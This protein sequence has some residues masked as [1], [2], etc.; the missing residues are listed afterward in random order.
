MQQPS[1]RLEPATSIVAR[2]GGKTAV[3]RA[4]GLSC[5][6]IWRWMQH[7]SRQGTGG[8]IPRVH[9]RALLV[10][11]QIHQIPLTQE[12]LSPPEPIGTSLDVDYAIQ[13][14]TQA[15]GLTAVTEALGVEV[16]QIVSFIATGDIP[17]PVTDDP[18]RL[19][20]H[21]VAARAIRSWARRNGIGPLAATRT[22]A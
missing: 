4:V 19:A 21:A 20:A 17:A 1:D 22:A 8:E 16:H 18:E 13:V 3:A 6:Q 9:H 7:R 5:V 14:I 11:A 10:Y 15:G 12:D 2:L